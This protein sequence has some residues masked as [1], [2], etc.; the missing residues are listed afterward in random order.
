MRTVRDRRA[1]ILQVAADELGPQGKGSPEVY[2]YWRRVLPPARTDAQVKLYAKT[3]EWCGGFVL[4]CIKAAG[5]AQD[6]FWR[7]SVGFVGPCKLELTTEPK[8]GDICIKP[9]PYAHHSLVEA[10]I[11][12]QLWTIDGNQP[13]VLRKR[14]PVPHDKTLT[15]YS[16]E[17]FLAA[18]PDT[19]PAPPLEEEEPAELPESGFLRGQPFS[20]PGI[21]DPKE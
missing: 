8:P 15:F 13:G 3:K 4:S 21:Q 12:G 9:L 20:V 10:Y 2:G 1:A 16:I 11:D 6:V 5:F 14:H 17:P 19:E 7:D 18:L